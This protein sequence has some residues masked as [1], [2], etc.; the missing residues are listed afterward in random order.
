MALWLY[1]RCLKSALRCPAQ[2]HQ[3][4]MWQYVQIGFRSNAQL[5]DPRHLKAKIEDARAQWMGME[6]LHDD[7]DRRQGLVVPEPEPS[8]DPPGGGST[9]CEWGTNDVQAWLVELGLGKHGAT[10]QSFG[11]DGTL[12]HELDMEDL[13]CEL[14]VESRL[15]RKKILAER[16]LLQVQND[17]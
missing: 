9:M 14:G 6:E 10:F 11:V 13:K 2:H 17:Q 7:R 12:L 4:E 5:S 8:P 1:R 3:R 15:E 16:S